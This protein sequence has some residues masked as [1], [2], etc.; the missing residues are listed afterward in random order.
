V[1][2]DNVI[3]LYQKIN[4]ILTSPHP[5]E[6]SLEELFLKVDQIG[7]KYQTPEEIE[8]F[9]QELRKE[10]EAIAEEIDKQFPEEELEAIDYS[11]QAQLSARRKKTRNRKR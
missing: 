9:N 10:V 4:D 1:G 2:W 6:P 8:D 7:S 5:D 11:Q 3:K